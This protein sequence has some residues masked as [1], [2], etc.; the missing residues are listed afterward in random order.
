MHLAPRASRDED[1]LVQIMYSTAQ[2]A[3]AATAHSSATNTLDDVFG[4]D[5]E[6]DDF[7]EEDGQQRQDAVRES[8]PSDIPRLQTEHATAGYREGITAAKSESIQ[9]GFDEGFSLGATVGLKAGQL[10]GYL[11]GMEAALRP[12]GG[13]VATQAAA[14]LAQATRELGVDTVFSEQYWAVDGTW[15]YAVAGDDEHGERHVVFDDVTD[16]HPLISKWTGVVDE[17]VR[18]WN[19]DR[20]VLHVDHEEASTPTETIMRTTEANKFEKKAGQA[21]LDW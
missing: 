10:L 11:E 1:V 5:T 3:A 13:H 12:G 16:A 20:Q 15:K 7:T 9:A 2:P 18:R 21:A 8:H 6:H 14:L 4:S 17:E 19:I